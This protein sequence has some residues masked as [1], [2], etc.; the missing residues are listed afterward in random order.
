MQENLMLINKP[1]LPTGC[2]WLER[3]DASSISMMRSWLE[4]CNN[5]HKECSLS[6]PTTPTLP[7]RIIDVGDDIHDP[8][9]FVSN[10]NLGSY[11]TL[12]HCWGNYVPLTTTKVSLQ[13]RLQAIPLASLPQTFRD[14]VLITRGL[15]LQYLWIDSLVLACVYTYISEHS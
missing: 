9:L 14:A 7:T 8:F 5:V 4:N 2:A 15:G 6:I 12:S 3:S 10:G 1:E 11:A 13:E